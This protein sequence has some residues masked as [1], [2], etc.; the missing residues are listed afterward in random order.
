MNQ[1]TGNAWDLV[2]GYLGTEVNAQGWRGKGEEA[3]AS[4]P[5]GCVKASGEQDEDLLLDKMLSETMKPS[6]GP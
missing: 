4:G 3:V 5:D 6:T 2:Q 1:S